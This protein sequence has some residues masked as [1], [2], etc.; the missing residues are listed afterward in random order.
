MIHKSLRLFMWSLLPVL[1]TP[2]VKG[3]VIIQYFETEWDEI[4]QRLPELA[5]IGYG[6]IWHPSPAKSPIG[7]DFPYAGGGNVGYSL[8]DRFDLGDIPQRGALRTRYGSKGSLQNMVD[9]AHHTDIKIYPDIIMNHAGNGPNFWTYPGMKPN[10]FHGWWD[11]GQPGGFKRAPRMNNYGEVNGGY[12]RTFQEELVSLIDIVTER[13]NRFSTGAPNYATPDVYI[14]Q[15]GQYENYPF[16]N[17]GD[18]LPAEHPTD[19]LNRWINWLGYEMDYDGV[20]LDAPKHVTADFF[21]VPGDSSAFNHNIQ[22]NYKDRHG[23]TNFN[24][25]DQMYLND[26]RRRDSA[27]IFS[28]FF[29]GAQSE[30]DYWKNFGVKMRYLDFPR[31]SGMIRPAFSDGNLAALTSFAGFSP[32]EGVMFAQSHDE[33]PPGKLELAYAYLLLRTGVPI[34][35]FTGNNLDQADVGNRTW[36]LTGHGG[37]LGD[38][39][40]KAIPNLIYIHNHFAR[41]REWE[42]WSEGDFYAFERY[43]DLNSNSNPD[44]G[45]SLLIVAL[46]DSGG[47]QTRTVQTAFQPDTVL[48]DYTGNN[49]NTVSVNSSGQATITVPGMGGQGFVAY[50]PKNV[51]GPAA[52]KALEFRDGATLVNE[53]DWIVPGGA[54]AADKPRT[55]P[56]ITTDTVNI[57]VNF[58]TNGPT[59]D[60]VMVKWGEGEIVSTNYYDSGNGTVSGGFQSATQVSP[61]HWRLAADVSGLPDGLHVVRGRVFNQRPGGL[62]ALFQT[63]SQVVYLDRSGPEIVFDNLSIGETVNGARMVQL[64]NPDK[65]AYYTEY[66]LDGST[67]TPADEV[68]KGRWRLPIAS[69]SNGPQTLTIK[70]FEADWGN[71]RTIINTTVVTR[72]FT[73]LNG[74]TISIS[75]PNPGVHASGN[76]IHLPFFTTQIQVGPGINQSQVRLFW[77]GL[78]MVNLS[79]TGTVHHVFDGRYK[80]GDQTNQLY[81]A[82]IN[83]PHIFEAMVIDGGQTN[84]A[85]RRVNFNLY[86]QSWIDSDGDGLPDDLEMP[87]FLNGTH[88]PPNAKWPGD[89]NQDMVPN[90]GEQWSRL[91]PMNHDTTYDNTWD[92]DEDWSGDGFSNLCKV[93]M[94]YTLHNNAGYFNIYDPNQ[95]PPNCDDAGWSL[96]SQVTWNPTNP[97]Q[98]EGSTITIN[99]KVNQGPLDGETPIYVHMGF[100]EWST[101]VNAHLMS[102]NGDDLWQYVLSVPAYATNINMVFRNAAEDKWDNNASANWKVN[103]TPCVVQTNYFVMDGT[104]DSSHYEISANGMKIWAATR[105]DNLYVATWSANGNAVGSDHFL[106]VTDE[107]GPPEAAPWGKAG[108]IFFSKADKPWI[109]AESSTADGFHTFNNGGMSGRTAMGVNGQALEGEINLLEVFGYIPDVVYLAAVAYGDDD[110]DIITSQAPAPWNGGDTPDIETMEFLPVPLASI[111]DENGDGYFDGGQPELRTVVNDNERDANYD[112]RRFFINELAAESRSITVRFRANVNPG[113]TLSDVEVFSNLN[114]RDFAEMEEDRNTVTTTSQ[115]TYFRAYAMT[116]VG[117]G[118]YEATLPVNKCGAYRINARYKVNGGAYRYYTDNG[119]RKDC[120]VVVSPTKA[121]DMVMYELNPLYAE[122]T[123][124][125]F[126]GRSTFKDLTSND[127][128][129]RPNKIDPQYFNEIGVNMIWLQPIHPIGIDNRQT[130]ES[131]G[132]DYDPGSPYA[133]RDYWKVSPLLGDPATDGQAMNEFTNFVYQMGMAGVGVMLDGTFNHSAWDAVIGEPATEH[134]PWANDPN[135]LIRQVRPQWYAKKGSYGE[136][137]S[138]YISASDHDIAVAPDRIDFGKWTDVAQFYFGKY[139]ALVQGQTEEWRDQFLSERDLFFGHDTYSREVWEY[140]AHYPIYWLEK[141]GHPEGTPKTESWRGIDGLRCDFAQGLPSEFWEYT[142]NKTRSVKW[143]FIFMAESLDGN[144]VVAGNPRHGLTYRSARHFDVLNENMVFYWRDNYFAKY[145][146][147]GDNLGTSDSTTQPV[148][149]QLDNRRNAYDLAPILLNLSGHD[150]IYPHSNQWRL[151]YA[152]ALLAAI[153]GVPMLMY[154]QEAGGQNDAAVYT[155]ASTQHNFARYELNFGKSIP[156]FKRYNHMTNVWY[157]GDLYMTPLTEAYGRVNNARLNSAALR[158]QL[159]YFLDRTDTGNKDPDITAI[160]KFQEAG[161]SAATQDVVFVFV[162]NNIETSTNRWGTFKLNPEVAPGVNWFGIQPGHDYQLVDLMSPAPTTYVWGDPESGADL[163]AN[164]LTVG[165]TG[166]PFAGQQAQYLRLVDITAGHTGSS[167]LNYFE[168]DANDNQLPD[169]WETQNSVPPG[170]QPHDVAPNG[171]TYWEN[172]IAGTDPNDINDAL[173]AFI[174]ANGTEMNVSWKSVNEINYHIDRTENLMQPTWSSIYF[175]T[176]YTNLQSVVDPSYSETNRFYRVRIKP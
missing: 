83:G 104:V 127:H 84:F 159:N 17:P 50:A 151:F 7:G 42:R 132:L 148:Y 31:K 110:E 164:G 59:A 134:F 12:G 46:N 154:G 44:E 167:V 78:E 112:I 30:V 137:A 118:W 139:D 153:D 1:L 150:E 5:E 6:G 11:A 18:P 107:F 138:Y 143:D 81:G 67:F 96:P 36:M 125:T 76:D 144:R 56:R 26:L 92:G 35:Y 3:E 23:Y 121:L 65:L 53:M 79:G 57:D 147:G 55:L 73:M 126:F 14:R 124:D 168:W 15:P 120:A 19:F 140:F 43:S 34:V 111:R 54:L 37:A 136:P 8:F 93:R 52:G 47:D 24:N 166:N 155:G 145:M 101:N 88:L 156:N 105:G 135:A 68:M 175:G 66:S 90:N 32:N 163:I 80:V 86:G 25:I 20:R 45:E 165:L 103:V 123:D 91:N 95:T 62:P 114:R 9:N 122:A 38:Y 172:L 108:N 130:D 4:Y 109:A 174:E 61:G 100:N 119:L 60:S 72:A 75:H 89:D 128:P 176:A 99:Y 41:D 173:R 28:E 13:D 158:S 29:I 82:F 58:S 27:L 116:D 69:L 131:T 169:G 117:G 33:G 10:D 77:D 142:I 161:I 40:H 48:H 51:D 87:N 71:P 74:P 152:H 97:N 85:V 2:S 160:A 171:M 133:V 39:G 141:T 49:G 149:N 94:G 106:L 21:G 98:C 129:G 113:D 63:F 162:N 102:N 22:Y 16:Q 64:S 146:G 157:N 170:T 115:D 70:S